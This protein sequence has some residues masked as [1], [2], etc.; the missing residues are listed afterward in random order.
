MIRWTRAT[1][2]HGPEVQQQPRP[3]ILPALPWAFSG[4]RG[5][6]GN[7]GKYG[8]DQIA[9]SMRGY[10]GLVDLFDG[11]L[12][13]HQVEK[14]QARGVIHTSCTRRDIRRPRARSRTAERCPSGRRA[15]PVGPPKPAGREYQLLAGCACPAHRFHR[16]VASSRSRLTLASLEPTVTAGHE[17]GAVTASSNAAASSCPNGMAGAARLPVAAAGS[18]KST[19]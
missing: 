13:A 4:R 2:G 9:R 15:R 11:R 3:C 14:Q 8:R 7:S 19:T 6:V 10:L 1:D 16:H 17:D 12:L 5:S 18:E